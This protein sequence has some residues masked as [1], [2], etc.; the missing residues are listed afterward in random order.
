[1][2]ETYISAADIAEGMTIV[3]HLASGTGRAIPMSGP[4]L[5]TKCRKEANQVQ[6][7]AT[8]ASGEQAV[9]YVDSKHLFAVAN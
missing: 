1:M 8:K 7:V 4:H 5:I 3:S 9:L 6:I 2:Q